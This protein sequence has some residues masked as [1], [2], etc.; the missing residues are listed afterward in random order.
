[1]APAAAPKSFLQRAQ[2]RRLEAVRKFKPAP[3]KPKLM[4]A[5]K[6]GL[7]ARQQE[8]LDEIACFILE[9]DIS[10]TYEELML[11]LNYA[12]KGTIARLVCGLAARGHI[13][14]EPRFARSIVL[15]DHSKCPHCGGA[16]T[17]GAQA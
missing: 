14:Y 16:L 15:V 4:G 1:M 8:C 13:T 12:S 9:R 5:S 17:R 10:P 11:R 3:A 2:E 7:T 6:L